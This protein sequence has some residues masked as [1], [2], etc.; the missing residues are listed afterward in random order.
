MQSVQLQVDDGVKAVG[1]ALAMLISD[2]KAKKSTAQIVSDALPLLAQAIGGL[3]T[4]G[5][6]LKKVDNQAYILRAIG[7]VLEA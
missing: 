3:G 4:L 7:I 5:A 2:L 1:D 6:D